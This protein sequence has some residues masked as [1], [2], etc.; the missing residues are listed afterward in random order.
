MFMK[1]GKK[2][3]LWHSH[4]FFLLCCQ[5]EFECGLLESQ[6]TLLMLPGMHTVLCTSKE[7]VVA[8]YQYMKLFSIKKKKKQLHDKIPIFI[9]ENYKIQISIVLNSHLQSTS[10]A[11]PP[12]N[13]LPSF[14]ICQVLC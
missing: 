7:E 8:F 5:A 12:F 6:T 1:A 10:Q 9:I 3:V 14:P 13:T 11:S 2:T 4:C